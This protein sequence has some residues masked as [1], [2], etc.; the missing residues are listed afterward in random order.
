VADVKATGP[1]MD[2]ELHIAL[3]QSEFLGVFPLKPVG[4]A[5]LIGM[6]PRELRG[7]PETA[8]WADVSRRAL[9]RMKIEVQQVNWFSTYHVHHRVAERFRE[10]R[11][12][13]LGDAAHIHSPVGGQGM[14]TGIGDA[15]NL[16]WKLAA[17]VQGRADEA[18]LDSYNP[19]RIAFAHRLVQTTD[20]VFTIATSSAPLV[21]GLRDQIAA[22]LVPAVAHARI[23][24]LFL[25]KTVSQIG[26]NYRKGPLAQGGAGRIVGGDRLPWAGPDSGPAGGDNFTPLA[27][28]DWQVHVYGEPSLELEEACAALNLALRAFIWRPAFWRAG[29]MRDAS[30]LIRPD[31]YVAMADPNA[32]PQTLR[33]FMGTLAFQMRVEPAASPAKAARKPAP[34][35]RSVKTAGRPKPTRA[36]TKSPP[37]GSA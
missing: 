17:V 5:R 9:E 25:F 20:R 18:L 2:R 3:D 30:Y 8:G 32:S 15:V 33:R 26:V 34:R 29:L 4:A 27:S 21:R 37:K 28:L 36:R 35:K 10:G 13:L 16:G 12:F 1:V 6:V 11:I 23:A 24:R 14:N 7:A 19:E 31:G 22:R